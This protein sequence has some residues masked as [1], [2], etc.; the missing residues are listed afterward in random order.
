MINQEVVWWT[1]EHTQSLVVMSREVE[2]CLGCF[3]RDLYIYIYIYINSTVSQSVITCAS[4][5]PACPPRCPESVKGTFLTDKHM[6]LCS[7]SSLAASIPVPACN[8][9]D[10]SDITVDMM[11]SQCEDP[12]LLSKAEAV[13]SL[14]PWSAPPPVFDPAHFFFRSHFGSSYGVL[15]L[16]VLLHFVGEHGES[17]SATW[18]L[19]RTWP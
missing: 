4:T 11:G 13:A 18:H 17:L 2:I 6:T 7:I 12:A 1:W 14:P 10:L 9:D 19:S 8:Q 3:L 5:N 15:S 16:P